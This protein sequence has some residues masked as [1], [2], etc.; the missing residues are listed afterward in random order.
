M[1]ATLLLL[2]RACGDAPPF[3]R[4]K[5]LIR[6]PYVN[7]FVENGKYSIHFDSIWSI[8]LKLNTETKLTIPHD[9]GIEGIPTRDHDWSIQRGRMIDT[10]PISPA[11]AQIIRTW[12]LECETR[13]EHCKGNH[14]S[15]TSR[16]STV[17]QNIPLPT[18]VIEINDTEDEMVRISNGTGKCG[19][20]LALSHRWVSGDRPQWVTTQDK[21][22]SRYN[23]F[24]QEDLP[25]SIINSIQVTRTLGL[26]YL[27]IDSLCIIQDSPSDWEIESSLMASIYSNAHITLFADCGLDDEAHGF[28]FP[29]KTF[30]T[31]QV[32]LPTKDGDTV[33][34]HLRKSSDTSFRAIQ[35]TLFSTNIESSYLS[36]RGWILQERILSRRVLQFGKDQMFWECNEGTFAEDGHVVVSRN[37]FECGGQR[38]NTFSKASYAPVLHDPRPLSPNSFTSQW[39]SLVKTYSTLYLTRSASP[40]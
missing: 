40:V 24:N 1:T 18:R 26:P 2:S 25:A 28:L 9:L 16:S 38:N 6:K 10:D 39:E 8:C 11:S 15:E 12:L 14:T 3:S 34:L 13:H 33:R 20:Y 30:P 35:S 7:M 27:W 31:T 29:R 19:T 37:Q 22:G 5:N 21:L 23:W 36:S 17:P 4:D 32:T